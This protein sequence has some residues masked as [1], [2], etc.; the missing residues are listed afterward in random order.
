MNFADDYPGALVPAR[1]TVGTVGCYSTQGRDD[2]Y[3][4][5]QTGDVRTPREAIGPGRIETGIEE[6]TLLATHRYVPADGTDPIVLA[7]ELDD[8][9][10]VNCDYYPFAWDGDSTPRPTTTWAI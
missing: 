9:D 4:L 7:R 2:V 10:W 6:G 1:Y 3:L 8:S 5:A